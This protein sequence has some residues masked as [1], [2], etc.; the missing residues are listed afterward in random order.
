MSPIH[1]DRHIIAGLERNLKVVEKMPNN[2]LHKVVEKTPNNPLHILYVED[3][4]ARAKMITGRLCDCVV[5]RVTGA[6]SAA[7]ILGLDDF[8]LVLISQLA[9]VISVEPL[10]EYLRQ[11]HIPHA[12]LVPSRDAIALPGRPSVSMV[13]VGDMNKLSELLV[14]S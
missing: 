5:T 9:G 2:P 3:Q 13:E 8:D 14:A 10:I 1:E 6:I 11:K 7:G 12:F 4:D